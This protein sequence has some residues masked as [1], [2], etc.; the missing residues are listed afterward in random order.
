MRGPLA[1][2]KL[3][4]AGPDELAV[5]V[6]V[7]LAHDQRAGPPVR[8]AQIR[9]ATGLIERFARDPPL[10]D[11]VQRLDLPVLPTLLDMYHERQAAARSETPGALPWISRPEPHRQRACRTAAS[12]TS[13]RSRTDPP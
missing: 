5:L 1:P 10:V 2:S 9:H 13:V 11:G 8:H 6:V 12:F 7:H 4:A 3:S